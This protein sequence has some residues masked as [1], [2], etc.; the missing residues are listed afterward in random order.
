MLKVNATLIILKVKFLPL[1]EKI[2][3]RNF[4]NYL[5]SLPQNYLL[6]IISNL[7]INVANMVQISIRF[8]SKLSD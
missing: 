2:K 8:Q 3:S 4:V 1:I 7:Q 6:L 5:T